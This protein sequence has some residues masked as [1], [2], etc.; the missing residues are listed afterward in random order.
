METNTNLLA[1]F[2]TIIC[3]KNMKYLTYIY[4]ATQLK[5]ENN[6]YEYGTLLNNVIIIIWVNKLYYT[7]LK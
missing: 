5:Y 4:Y 1:M 3:T 7:F 2:S 6:K